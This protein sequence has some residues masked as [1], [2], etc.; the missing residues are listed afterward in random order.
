[1]TLNVE[2]VRTAA[3]GL[4]DADRIEL[5]EALIE[6]VEGPVQPSLDESWREEI[7]TRSA[8]LKSGSVETVPW[9]EVKREARE[10][11]GG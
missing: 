2:Q 3:L 10:A 11:I 4:P 8:E 9:S 5:I 1:M 7:R 6:S